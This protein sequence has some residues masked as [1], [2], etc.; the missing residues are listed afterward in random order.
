MDE[1]QQRKLASDQVEEFYHDLFVETQVQHF[2]GI[3]AP[4][5]GDHHDVVADVGGGAAILPLP[6]RAIWGSP[7]V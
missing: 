2:A 5:I 7:R 4:L 1:V 6:C 3:C